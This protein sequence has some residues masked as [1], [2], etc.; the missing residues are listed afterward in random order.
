VD[1]KTCF[2]LLLDGLPG[3]DLYSH[4][5]L[6]TLPLLLKPSHQT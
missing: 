3:F 2:L 5:K 6:K 1:K 4:Q